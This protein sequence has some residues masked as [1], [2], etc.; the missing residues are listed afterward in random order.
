MASFFSFLA[1][2]CCTNVVHIGLVADKSAIP[3][4]YQALYADIC[5][6]IF[7]LDLSLTSRT[8]FN[9]IFHDLERYKSSR[10]S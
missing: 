9:K 1:R 10:T 2:I 6:G 5:P 4:Q 8:V 3:A 7:E